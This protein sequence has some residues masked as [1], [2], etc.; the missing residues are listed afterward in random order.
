MKQCLVVNRFNRDVSLETSFEKLT[1]VTDC[2]L[3]TQRDDVNCVNNVDDCR[4]LDADTGDVFQL[5]NINVETVVESEAVNSIDVI[6]NASFKVATLNYVDV[7]ID[8]KRYKALE[9]SGCQIPVIKR[10]LIETLIVP[11]LDE[12]QLQGTVVDPVCAPLVTLNVKCRDDENGG[13]IGIREPVPVVFAAADKLV[14]CDVLLPPSIIH[15]LRSVTP[16]YMLP[17]VTRSKTENVDDL[18]QVVIDD[19]VNNDSETS[20]VH[21]S[22]ALTSEMLSNEQAIDGS[23]DPYFKA[24]RAGKR[25]F[26]IRNAL[27]Y[28][29]DQ[30]LGLKVQKL[31]LPVD[32]RLRVTELAHKNHLGYK[33]S[34][35]RIRL[36]FWWPNLTKDVELYCTSSEQCQLRARKRVTDRV[37]ITPIARAELPFQNVVIDCIVPIDRRVLKVAIVD[38]VSF[39]VRR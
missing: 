14:G 18:N 17:V 28:H 2:P 5:M 9:D 38:S 39:N 22:N 19:V 36:S 33:R 24:V 8:G 31:C 6:D 1:N 23:L 16:C 7:L 32:R 3:R 30:V 35:E 11:G 34:K 15:E 4:E 25:D 26:V 37:P 10:Q 21:L 27:L 29:N 12:I 20:D 13:R